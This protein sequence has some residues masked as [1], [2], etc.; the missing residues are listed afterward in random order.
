[1]DWTDK[2]ILIAEDEDS[3]YLYL[4]AVLQKTGAK[5]IWARN[6]EEAI[7]ACKNEEKID[8]V[9]MDLQ[10][11]N[12]NGYQA[13]EVI[14]DLSPDTPQIAQTAFAMADDEKRAMDAGFDAYISKPIRKNNLLALV[15]RFL[16]PEK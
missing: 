11:P 4:E 12:I 16:E 15:G 3:N 14:K 5:L 13:R 7:E 1:M 10:M 8:L 2:A 6:G 9:L